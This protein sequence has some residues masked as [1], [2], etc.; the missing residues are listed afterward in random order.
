MNKPEQLRLAADIIEK[1]LPWEYKCCGVWNLVTSS[2][3]C[4]NAFYDGIEI[5]LAPPPPEP[6]PLTAED[7]PPGSV[8]RS[9]YNPRGWVAPAFIRDDGLG[10]VVYKND[11]KVTF[12]RYT[13]LL[14]ESYLIKRPGEEWKPC[15]K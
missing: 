14:D 8:I 6:V 2:N 4:E 1:N 7:V 13:T 11:G 5:R 10:F 12:V 9:P 3:G 15:S